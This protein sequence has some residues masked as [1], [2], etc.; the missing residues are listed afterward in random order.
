MLLHTEL[1]EEHKKLKA[2]MVNFGGWEMPVIY[3]S[4]IDEHNAVRT[5]AGIFDVGHMGIITLEGPECLQFIQKVTTNNAKNLE[6][7]QIQYSMICNENG[8]IIDDIL[9]SRLAD[10]YMLVINASNTK[11]VLYWLEK[12]KKEEVITTQLNH[13][14][15][16]LA[17]QGP[18]SEEI[19]SRIVNIDLANLKYYRLSQGFVLGKKAI[20][21]RTGY[22]GEDGFEL[23]LRR[24]EIKIVW[25]YFI[26]NNIQPCGLGARDTLR[27]EAGMP[28]YG[29]ELN[30]NTTPLSTHLDWVVKFDK[31]FI[32]KSAIEKQ[33]ELGVTS[34]IAGIEMLSKAIPREGY[35]IASGGVVTSGTFSPTL[36]KPIGMVLIKKEETNPGTIIEVSIRNKLHQAR[37]I[38]LPFYKRKK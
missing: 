3:K 35:A 4:V 2:K 25:K 32:G 1:N 29:H 30:E 15:S 21:S 12:N 8:G 11:K 36:Q 37:T 22:T 10:K 14:H 7:G 26:E 13:T 19:L 38:E 6:V 9:V 28:L 23:I 18:K 24:D 5:E 33:K 16:M 34:K 17:I 20:I 27:L 31:D